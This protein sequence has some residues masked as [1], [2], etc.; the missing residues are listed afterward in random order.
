MNTWE[1]PGGRVA[2][3]HGDTWILWDSPTNGFALYTGDAAGLLALIER[4]GWNL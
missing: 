4:K 1:L 3:R 2:T